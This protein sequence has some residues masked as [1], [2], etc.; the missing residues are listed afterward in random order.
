MK[1]ARAEF[2]GYI[3][4]AGQFQIAIPGKVTIEVFAVS[5]DKWQARLYDKTRKGGVYQIAASIHGDIMRQVEERFKAQ[6]CPWSWY[7]EDD[8]RTDAPG[9]VL[10][11][12]WHAKSVAGKNAP[13]VCGIW[14]PKSRVLEKGNVNK[15]TCAECRKFL[16]QQ[17]DGPPP[18]KKQRSAA[19]PDSEAASAS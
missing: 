2:E 11:I 17:L 4:T 18:E 12:H 8:N 14:A 15:I 6:L 3:P 16:Q 5:A 1:F 7:D 9:T 19:K 10:P 13:S